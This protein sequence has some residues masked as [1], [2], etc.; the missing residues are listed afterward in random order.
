[1]FS[2]NVI[3]I[4]WAT[5]LSFESEKT[6]FNAPRSRRSINDGAVGSS[7]IQRSKEGVSMSARI[8]RTLLPY[9]RHPDRIVKN[10][11]WRLATTECHRPIVFV[12]GAPR[13]GTTLLQRILSVHPDCFSLE[14]ETG[15]FSH[16]DIFARLH[17]GLGREETDAL[18]ATS[19]DIVDFM[20][21][22]IGILEKKY[23]VEKRFVEKTPQH[24]LKMRFLL[25]RFPN[26]RFLHIHRDGRDCYCSSLGHP[27]IPQK[28][29]TSFARYWRRCVLAGLA[30]RSHPRAMTLSYETLTA[31]PADTISS[32]MNFLGAAVSAEQVDN[33]ALGRDRRS[34]RPEFSRLGKSLML[35]R[36]AAGDAS[37][38]GSSKTPSGASPAMPCRRSDIS[39]DKWPA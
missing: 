6:E 22:G 28:S 11:R 5:G 23:G 4:D 30:C 2:R 20:C 25:D 12:L 32:I 3:Q 36:A 1:L 34:A 31:S 21:K 10:I 27:F 26:A 38:R 7:P 8:V 29:V 24:V 17:F 9:A 14:S 19:R 35:R 37:C 16:Q 13:S 39:V 33:M 15:L 18:F